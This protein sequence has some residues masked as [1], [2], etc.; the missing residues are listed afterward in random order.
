M[1]IDIIYTRTIKRLKCDYCNTRESLSH[2]HPIV[3]IF[4]CAV[5]GKDICNAHTGQA[6]QDGNLCVECVRKGY[7]IEFGDE[8]EYGTIWVEDQKGNDIK[9][10]FL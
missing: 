6:S 8:E 2:E 5:C 7:S 4:R 9:A 1:E 3:Y 10:P